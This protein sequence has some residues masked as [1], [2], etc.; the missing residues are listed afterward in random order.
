VINKYLEV[1]FARDL[2]YIRK[3]LLFY[4][5]HFAP[6]INTPFWNT[7]SLSTQNF[8][9]EVYT[10][11]KDIQ[12]TFCERSTAD[13][14]VTP[15]SPSL[16]SPINDLF[17]NS[18]S[19]DSDSFNF[20]DHKGS[21]SESDQFDD[22]THAKI[23]LCLQNMPSPLVDMEKYCNLYEDFSFNDYMRDQAIMDAYYEQCEKAYD[24][25]VSPIFPTVS[26]SSVSSV[27]LLS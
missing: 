11:K 19:V 27:F 9:S 26:S 14:P 23:E 6:F 21:F 2:P 8:I 3:Y 1:Q 13:Y 15:I 4:R 16:D 7:L 17:E 22:A 12:F 25:A 20:D 18:L 24:A 10:E 5:A